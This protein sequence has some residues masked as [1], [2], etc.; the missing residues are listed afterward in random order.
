[1]LRSLGHKGPIA[2]DDEPLVLAGKLQML[3]AGWLGRFGLLLLRECGR[4]KAGRH[5]TRKWN[6]GADGRT[7]GG[8]A[9]AAKKTATCSVGAA[10]ED[11]CVSTLRI[12]S[13]KF[14]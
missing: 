1:M 5:V 13:V 8:N 3:G 12:V 2:N 11:D 7:H 9:C 6:G 14:L 4:D 10:P